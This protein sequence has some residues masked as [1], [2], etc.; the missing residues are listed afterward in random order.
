MQTYCKS[1]HILH[2]GLKLFYHT[3]VRSNGN[4][5]EF[6]AVFLI[7]MLHS[8]YVAS[9][10]SCTGYP[11]THGGVTFQLPNHLNP[12]RPHMVWATSG[13]AALCAHSPLTLPTQSDTHQQIWH[14]QS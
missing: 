9:P 3:Q 4:N 10:E 1:I 14:L 7:I 12:Q 5:K 13:L 11:G 8:G 2:L 6:C